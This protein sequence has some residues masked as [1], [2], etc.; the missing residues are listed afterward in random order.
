[1]ISNTW[2]EHPDWFETKQRKYQ[3][4]KIPKQI[5]KIQKARQPPRE[6]K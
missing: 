6:N 1:M 2:G 3:Q 4:Q 5:N